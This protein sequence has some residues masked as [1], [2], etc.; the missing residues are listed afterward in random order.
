MININ[1][2]SSLY[3]VKKLGIDD[4]DDILNL[5][6]ENTY[7]FS[8]FNGLP[9][10]DLVKE[11]LLSLPN[12]KTNDDKYFIGLYL[13][14]ALICVIDL[15]ENYPCDNEVYIGLFMINY[16]FQRKGIGTGI[17]YELIKSLS[18]QNFKRIK[19]GCLTNNLISFAFWQKNGFT[20]SGKNGKYYDYDV[21]ELERGI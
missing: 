18:K 3:E 9:S 12:G 4:I 2:I 6:K 13:K 21:I 16:M 19:L 17:I 14:D 8:C 10:E 11:D 15:V 1:E 7:Y 20:P 5:Y